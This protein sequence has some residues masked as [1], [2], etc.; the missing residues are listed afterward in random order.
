MPGM[1]GIAGQ[2]VAANVETVRTLA[3]VAARAGVRWVHLGSLGVFGGI[4]EGR[5]TEEAELYPVGAYEESKA[6]ADRA[7]LDEADRNGLAVSILRPAAV[8]DSRMPSPWLR[9][10]TT[11]LSGKRPVL[12]AGGTGVLA[13]SPLPSVV[14]ALMACG[15]AA[16][17]GARIFHLAQSISFARLLQICQSGGREQ[18]HAISIPA[19]LARFVARIPG[20][21]LTPDQVDTLT[22]SVEFPSEK[23][24]RELGY[25]EQHAIE[26]F[27]E[28]LVAGWRERP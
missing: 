28:G 4:R 6:A 11:L 5:L 8:V 24:V 10:L 12:V 27:L 13:L 3:P 26:P 7:L 1:F 21:P 17:E 15:S 25:R 14:E 23:I 19:W 9:R 20:S 2:F 22:R 18:A 16:C